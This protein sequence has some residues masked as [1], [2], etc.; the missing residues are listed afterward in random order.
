MSAAGMLR[1]QIIALVACCASKSLLLWLFREFVLN[2]CCR[3]T[4][5]FLLAWL[6]CI[7]FTLWPYAGWAMVPLAAL[8]MQTGRPLASLTSKLAIGSNQCSPQ[9]KD[10]KGYARQVRLRA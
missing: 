5:R 3:H 2:A 7:P 1:Q 9:R 4:A 10:R 6:F 8:A